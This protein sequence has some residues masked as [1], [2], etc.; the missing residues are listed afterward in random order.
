MTK[1]KII[2]L[3][4]VSSS[5]KTTLA[6]ILQKKLSEPYYWL[7]NDTFCDMSPETLWE[8]D[9]L[10]TEYQALT[11]LNHTVKLFSDM[12]KNTI[13]D[14]VLISAQKSGLLKE[15][16][17][18]LCDYPVLFVHV[19]CP[20]HELQRREK[21]RG[22]RSIGQAEEQLAMLTPQDTYD[23]TV[24]T[25]LDSADVCADKIIN[26]IDHPDSFKAFKLLHTHR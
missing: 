1:G 16:V 21:E 5:G 11:M 8:R 25:F 23:I 24:D 15:C 20:V 19:T 6:R 9:N 18:L 2:Y 13:V 26:L 10:E 7:A 17:D 14:N 3:N 4:G 22:D 12:G